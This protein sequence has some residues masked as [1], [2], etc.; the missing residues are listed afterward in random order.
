MKVINYDYGFIPLFDCV[1]KGK[2]QMTTQEF[3][4]IQKYLFNP[5]VKSYYLDKRLL[6][7]DLQRRLFLS[8]GK[9]WVNVRVSATEKLVQRFN[10]EKYKRNNYVL[11]VM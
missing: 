10:L 1:I 3:I 11:E 6:K 7:E 4:K 2:I 8:G 5:S 9:F